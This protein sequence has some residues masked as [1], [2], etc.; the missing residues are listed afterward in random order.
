MK[1]PAGNASSLETR[2]KWHGNHNENEVTRIIKAGRLEMVYERGNLRHI[3]VE[4]QEILRMIYISVR[5]KEWLTINPVISGE[6][7]E[8]RP[9]SF[10]INYTTRYKSGEIDFEVR[11]SIEGSHNDSLII[12]MEGEA[13]SS[14]EKNRIGFCILHP[15]R[16]CS[17]NACII[18]HSNNIPETL[19]FP[20]FVSPTRPFT[21]IS[22]MEWKVS[23]NNC[24]LDFHGDVFETED[25]RNWTDASYK[26]YSTPISI[27]YPVRILKGEKISQR[28]ELKI[29]GK[30][31][32]NSKEYKHIQIT[33]NPSLSF[34]MPKIGIGKSSRKEHLSNNEIQTLKNLRF[35][36]YRIEIHLFREWKTNADISVKE[37]VALDYPIELAVFVDSAFQS[38]IFD[39]A[40]WLNQRTLR[41]IA[42]ILLHKDVAATPVDIID[43]AGP[44][45]LRSL[46][47]VKIVAGT[48][49]NF[50]QL[51]KARPDSPF[52]DYICYSIHPQ[53]HAGDNLT[54]VENLQGQSYTVE[55]AK[56]FPGGKDVWISPVNIQRR[57]NAN[58]GYYEQDH[59]GD[60]CPPQV[61]SRLMSL[62]GAGW[63]VGS[64]KYL[65]E[66]GVKGITFFETL[67]ERGIM[68]GDKPSRWREDFPSVEGMVFPVWFVFVFLLQ[69]KSIRVIKSESTH[70]LDVNCMVFSDGSLFRML[71][72]NLTSIEQK[73]SIKVPVKEVTSKMLNEDTYDEAVS[74][75]KWLNNS[76]IR[77]LI[78]G[79]SLVL[80]P[81]SSCFLEEVPS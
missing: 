63:T 72:V 54:L 10:R 73:V 39:F 46:P 61:D 60:N 18:T 42:V 38:Q 1:L 69:N 70:P 12:S 67:G 44:L 22:S 11:C 6:E 51:N 31:N 41:I 32:I 49:A 62:L 37:A 30:S 77:V 50:A 36:H 55:S 8:I 48:N 80:N 53:E 52:M 28:V 59:Y 74:N 47:N 24:R 76:S 27:P 23:E 2:I 3:S 16:E 64:L 5:V 57:F 17:G 9:D 21:D 29:K 78:S 20:Q 13:L 45:I 26:T 81:Y 19:K 34:S 56:K 7:F 58:A 15:V 75:A 79:D 4:N 68:Q 66:N 71:I 25:Q 65:I 14:F 35:D 33:L 40:E 43:F